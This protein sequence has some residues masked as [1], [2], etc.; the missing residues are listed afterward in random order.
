MKGWNWMVCEI[1][2]STRGLSKWVGGGT[3][4]EEKR[5]E[6]KDMQMR[7][8]EKGEKRKKRR[9]ER[10]REKKRMAGVCFEPLPY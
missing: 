3:T 5:G 2:K 4:I 7:K 8:T 10:E 1:W 6:K 9:G